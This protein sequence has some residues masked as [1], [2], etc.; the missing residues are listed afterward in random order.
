MLN[1]AL[2]DVVSGAKLGLRKIMS[3]AKLGFKEGYV[4]C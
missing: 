4:R 2:R 1:L 3:G